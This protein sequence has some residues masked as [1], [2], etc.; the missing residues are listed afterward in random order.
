MKGTIVTLQQGQLDFA[1]QHGRY[2]Y[3]RA[4]VA[5]WKDTRGVGNNLVNHEEGA[6]G[7][8]A[9]RIYLGLPPL[10]LDADTF[11]RIPD[12]PG[13]REVRFGSLPHYGLLVREDDQ[14]PPC[15]MRR[16]GLVVPV[17]QDWREVGDLNFRIVGWQWPTAIDEPGVRELGMDEKWKQRAWVIPQS[18]LFSIEDW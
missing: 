14:E 15:D 17:V 11:K 3:G 13:D 9:G 12:L 6:I 2:R 4:I 7:E 10:D 8:V 1:L 18:L 5:G 16:Y